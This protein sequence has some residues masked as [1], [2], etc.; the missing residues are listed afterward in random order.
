MTAPASMTRRAALA[1]TGIVLLLAACG[2]IGAPTARMGMVKDPATGLQFG[3][4]VERTI[5]TDPSFYKNRKI[6]VRTRNTS[7]DV[8]FDLDGFADELRAA[9]AASGFEPTEGEDFG[10]LLDVNVVYSGQM[11]SNLADEFG[12]LGAAGGG[13]AGYRSD[14]EAGT[15]IGTVAG[16]TFGTVLGS[17]VTDD[18]YII[19]ARVTFGEVKAGKA[20][21]K[22]ITF[23]RSYESD[24]QR[25]RIERREGK[26]GFRGTVSTDVTVF[27]GGRNVPQ[28]R[29]AGQ[30]RQRLA[31]IIGDV[32]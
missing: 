11:Q 23:S 25:E 30:V 19:V 32:I 10:L 13:I 26:R 24:E 1:A 28:S 27:A 20:A 12:F 7:G 17:F 3:S 22:R 9:Y 8:A 29:I 31:R 5:V 6:K 4:V 21:G 2:G 16:A 18:T 14:V 15:A